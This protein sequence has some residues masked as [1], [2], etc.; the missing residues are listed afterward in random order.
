M[1]KLILVPKNF[2]KIFFIE[3]NIICKNFSVFSAKPKNF[4][5]NE[6]F[7]YLIFIIAR[8]HL[9]NRGVPCPKALFCL[10]TTR[11]TWSLTHLPFS[12]LWQLT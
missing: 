11:L 9:R 5:A 4:S 1:P 2:W 6:K 10:L 7:F 3:K 8:L 12:S